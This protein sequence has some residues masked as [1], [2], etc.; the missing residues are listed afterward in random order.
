MIYLNELLIAI[1]VASL[2][3][4]IKFAIQSHRLELKRVQEL[5]DAKIAMQLQREQQ[6]ELTD[7]KIAM[8]LQREETEQV[9]KDF[10]RDA[11]C[12]RNLHKMI[13]SAEEPVW[14]KCPGCDCPCRVDWKKCPGCNFLL[15]A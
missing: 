13:N 12:A 11:E 2:A 8:Q 15:N 9:R 4:N 10:L 5:T 3:W 6:Q 7:A 1:F 14:N